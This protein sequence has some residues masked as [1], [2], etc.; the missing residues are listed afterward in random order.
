MLHRIDLKLHG[1]KILFK[2]Y[3]NYSCIVKS[4]VQHGSVVG[5][6]F[7]FIILYF[8][9]LCI[10]YIPWDLQYIPYYSIFRNYY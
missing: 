4:G 9:L 2:I 7:Y 10:R 6:L 8:I 1:L 3:F 5:I